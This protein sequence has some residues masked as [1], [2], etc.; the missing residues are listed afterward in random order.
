MDKAES[1]FSG[2][3]VR[4]EL[5]D[6][7]YDIYVGAGILGRLG[8]YF[9]QVCG[10]RRVVVI[11][12]EN[13]G[14][15][16]GEAALGSLRGAGIKADLL[17]VGAGE[18]SKRM[19]VVETL[20]DKLFDLSVE[21]SD[22]ILALGGGVVGDLA[23]FVA[24]TFKR[25]IDYIQVPTSLL[26]MVD[27]SIGGKTGINH[28]RGKNMIGAFHQPQMVFA[29]TETLRTLPRRELGC[30]LAETVK[31]AV[32]RDGAF[33]DT[34]EANS[35]V[36]LE[37]QGELMVQLVVRNCKIKASVVAADEREAGLRGILNY[38][39]TVGHAIETVMGSSGYHHGEAVALGMAAAG[40]I[41]VGRAMLDS[42]SAV[43]IER[44]L[45][46]FG[47]RVSLEGAVPVDDLYAAMWHD[48]K[49]I[50]G[51]MRFVLPDSLG[52]CEFVSDL[53]EA[54]I[55]SAIAS[56]SAGDGVVQ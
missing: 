6:R 12:D 35:G 3:K 56:L 37:L 48:K 29:D 54:E 55:K 32:I 13:V 28:P 11:T 51:K 26:A 22:A 38:G 36:I 34:L 39:H 7:S 5:G 46:A 30:G 23:G 21:R 33:F 8:E 40:R 15:L 20:Y 41:A 43:R 47:L 52:S 45:E 2:E 9:E 31:H 24:A 1:A 25:G 14:P 42:Q 17:S 49:V 50:V 53:S 27:S 44:L 10:R 19:A 4:V 18:A 16:Y